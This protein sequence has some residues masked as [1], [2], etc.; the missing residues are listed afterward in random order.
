MKRKNTIFTI[1]AAILPVAVNEL[2]QK[3]LSNLPFLAKVAISFCASFIALWICQWFLHKRD[4][5]NKYRG[6]W[7]EEMVQYNETSQPQKKFIGIGSIQYDHTTNE[8][9]FVGKTYEV[10]GEEV[11][12]WSIDYLRADKDTSMQYVCLVQ[13]PLERSIGKITFHSSNECEGL[14]W[15]MN[16]ISYKYNAYRITKDM[17]IELELSKYL[18]KHA[19]CPHY[20]GMVISQKNCPEFVKK[21]CQARFQGNIEPSSK[22]V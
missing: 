14:I 1:I 8:H 9:T 17:L 18:E 13:D 6:Q 4:H 12:S 5:L 2:V 11:Y 10:T 3:I 7:V 20:K 15:C 16:G 19:R 22:Q 21:Y